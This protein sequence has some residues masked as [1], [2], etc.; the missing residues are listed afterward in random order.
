[1]RRVGVLLSGCG[2]YDGSEVQETVLVTLALRRHGLRPVY[3]APDAEQRDVVDH[4]TGTV[5]D[6]APPRRVIEESS[7]LTRGMI[8][9]VH[10]LAVSELDAL[11]IPGGSGVIKNLCDADG[12]L[13]GGPPRPEVGRLLDDLRKRGAPVAAVGLAEVVL[14]RHRQRPLSDAPVS[15]PPTEIR[16][17]REGGE[18]FTPG[19][20]AT[21]E[22]TEVAAGIGALIDELAD[23]IGSKRRIER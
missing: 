6:A 16:V 1:M 4:T 17:D 13:G 7:R 20:M 9:A 23:W 14:A 11:V 18:L 19:F 8:Q 2:R 22:I 21:D 10:E 5:D 15:V 12:S 3:L